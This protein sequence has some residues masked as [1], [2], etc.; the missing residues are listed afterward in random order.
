M[1][2]WTPGHKGVEGNEQADEQV[3]KAITE[4]SSSINQLPQSLRKPLP[5]SK[6]TVKQAYNEKLKQLAQKS[7]MKSPRYEHMKNLEPTM[8]SKKY[9]ALIAPL[10]RKATSILSQ[11]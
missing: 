2:R 6:S 1:I 4:G 10:P 7:W 5:H 11:L 9:L 3:K 8:P